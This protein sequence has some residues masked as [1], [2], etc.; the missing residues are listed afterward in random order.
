MMRKRGVG[1][2]LGALAVLAGAGLDRIELQAGPAISVGLKANPMTYN[3][4]CPVQVQFSIGFKVTGPCT[5]NY[6]FI[7]DKNQKS[8]TSTLNSPAAGSYQAS[9]AITVTDKYIGH[10]DGLG[11][12]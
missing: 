5:I 9:Q 10:G 4:E 11:G 12:L 8:E 3:G 1:G 2:C 7:N 6:H